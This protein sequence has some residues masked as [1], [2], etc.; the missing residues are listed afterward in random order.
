MVLLNTGRTT[1]REKKESAKRHENV[2]RTKP[3]RCGMTQ[4]GVL[5]RTVGVEVNAHGPD[6]DCPRLGVTLVLMVMAAY[7]PGLRVFMFGFR[8]FY[9]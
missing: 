3:A 9:M 1:G 8:V 5:Y 6:C 4:V 7:V 2:A